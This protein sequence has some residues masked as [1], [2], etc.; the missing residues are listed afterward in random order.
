MPRVYVREYTKSQLIS[1]L[2]RVA[3]RND[4]R[5]LSWRRYDQ[6]K[7]P[8]DPSGNTFRSPHY[9]GTWRNALKEAGLPLTPPLRSE[10]KK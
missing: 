2:R 9:F 7:D 8:D 10:D 5:P 3:K 6:L 4:G 1:I